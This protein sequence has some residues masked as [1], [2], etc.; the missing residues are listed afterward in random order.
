MQLPLLFV[1]LGA[2]CL[3]SGCGKTVTEEDCRAVADH[4]RAVWQAEWDRM[5]ARAEGVDKPASVV[6][7]EGD[8]LAADWVV[9]CKAKLVGNPS[10]RKDMR[11]L[12]D[13]KTIADIRKCSA[14]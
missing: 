2:S 6:K 9:E 12:L 3:L 13:A 7:A 5:A 14:L 10:D 8:K 11:C 1:L 4:L